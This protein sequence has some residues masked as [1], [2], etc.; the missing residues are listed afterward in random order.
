MD[1]VTTSLLVLVLGKLAQDVIADACKDYLKNKLKQLFD[2]MEKIGQLDDVERAYQD[3]MEQA[4]SE[5][6][7]ML[8]LNIKGYG[9]GDDELKEYKS[10]IEAFLKDHQV[11]DELL[12]AVRE[13]G[14][15][16]LPSADVLCERWNDLGG[17]E[18]P[19][20][21][22]WSP[23]VIAFRR[24]ATKRIILSDDL[25]ELLNAQNIQQLKE[26]IERQGGVKVPVRR[27]KYSQR[28]QTKFSPVDLANLM[29]ASADDPGKI[30]IRDVFV[31][32]NVRE[33]PPPVEIPKDLVERLRKDDCHKLDAYGHEI[34][35][36]R[37]F[38][39]LHS[40]YVSQASK[41]VLDVIADP[42]NRLLVLIGE[43]GSGKSTLMR[44]LLT[45]IINPP[46]DHECGLP[47]PW[48]LAFNEAFPLLI[49]LRDFYAIRKDSKC[50]SFLEYVAYMG[51]TEQW[52]LD[53]HAVDGF[54][55]NGPSLVMFD[56]LDEI[57]NT[58]DRERV[59]QEIAGFAQRYPKTRIIVTSRPVGYKEQI[60]RNAGFV[61]FGI[62]D[63][64]DGQIETFT[65]GWFALIFPLYPQE[66]ERRIE[67]VLGSVRQ[68]K[69]IRLLA[70]NPMLLTIM[71]L[72]AREGELPR[73]RA[74]FYEKAAEVL[75]H[76]WD[77][78]RNLMLPEDRYLDAEDKKELLRRIAM[79]MQSG[80]GG[81]KGNII[82]ED[83]LEQE[84]QAYL[85]DEQLQPNAVEAKQA[86]RRM[87]HQL[88]ERNYILCLR[89]SH[90]YGFVHRTFLEYLTA[91]G[92]VRWFDK[93][94][95][96]MTIDELIELF[97]EH[98]PHDEWSEVLCLICG[99][100]D[101]QFVGRIV[102]RLATR[103]D[104]EKWDGEV[105]IPEIL[106][107]V[108]CLAESRST[109][110]LEPVVRLLLNNVVR[111]IMDRTIGFNSM[112]F[113][114]HDVIPAIDHSWITWP[115]SAAVPEVDLDEI[116]WPFHDQNPWVDFAAAVQ[117][118]RAYMTSLVMQNQAELV[119]AAAIR[120]LSSKWPDETTRKLLEDRIVQDEKGEARR[121]AILALAE[122][123]PDETTRKLLEDRTVQDEDGEVCA[124]AI[125][126]LAEHWTN[127]TTRK[128]LEDRAVQD[129]NGYIRRAS[130][131]ALA[132]KWPDKT[133]RKLLEDRAIR[134]EKGYVRHSAIEA[135]AEKWPDETTRKLLEDRAVNDED[136]YP[137]RAVI[138]ALADKW[139][140]ETTRKLLE[141]RAVQDE[142]GGICATAI[143]ALVKKWSDDTTR[144]LLEDRAVNGED[145]D[146]RSAAILALSE[147]WPDNTTR[148]LLEDRAVQDESECVRSNAIQS[149]TVKWPDETT[150]KLLEDCAV[151][152]E[153]EC[154]RC[155]AIW[156]LADKWPDATTQKLIEKRASVDGTAAS[157]LGKMHSQF[158]RI[159]FTIYL[160]GVD[161]YL[162]LTQPISREH[163]EQ[164][165][166]EARVPADKIDETVRSLSEHMGW[167]ITKGSGRTK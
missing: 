94:P 62:Q 161:P 160:D 31:A 54:L 107:A 95:Q 25:R 101:E 159:V 148:K 66:A 151:N 157:V 3:V 142:D 22:I 136:E 143:W 117:F 67:R 76:N 14:R 119:S 164:A 77:A 44:Y 74:K 37:I 104:L 71:A 120:V 45:G 152:D 165:A 135:L 41:P 146:A 84:I 61:H 87:I 17:K 98:C 86:A 121:A 16:N 59:M 147:Y 43:P 103:T 69:P 60:L 134:D 50:D 139:S 4:Y 46:V 34:L 13:S 29:P 28:M 78:N 58:A 32:Q 70:G 73:E 7:E 97:D 68:L 129:E 158:G 19:S 47:L 63:L 100:I 75:C 166:K 33:N 51:K 106:L 130:I 127:E 149:L 99:Q 38:E 1:L 141:D 81:L 9:Y 72:L 156:D 10:S 137:R 118:G 49:E 52:S 90:L 133:I 91:T 111:L 155:T 102:N 128:L 140:D 163:I 42:G 2:K 56:G 126:A 116:D 115:N 5:C 92:Y 6:L 26:L 154:V 105:P 23:V 110:K 153:I 144:K 36:D 80:D 57:F 48:T 11:A 93:Q 15:D 96:K 123:W 108:N 162:D 113:F 55:K 39:K 82:H 122:H 145:G 79:R 112:L 150:R 21:T 131:K 64:D 89:G 20:D 8:M 114:L 24:Q 35:D 125:V 132:E 83:D 124:A 40:A 167:D 85:I 109:K 12:N 30:V 53:D 88:R 27:D 138:Q 65:R 18:L